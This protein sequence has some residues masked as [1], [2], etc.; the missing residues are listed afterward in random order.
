MTTTKRASVA[1]AQPR[2]GLPSFSDNQYSVARVFPSGHRIWPGP[3]CIDTDGTRRKAKWCAL[4]IAG[5][6]MDDALDRVRREDAERREREATRTR[7]IAL[8][9][10]R[11]RARLARFRAWLVELRGYT[12]AAWRAGGF[13]SP[14]AFVIHEADRGH[15]WPFH[16]MRGHWA[17]RWSR[18]FMHDTHGDLGRELVDSPEWASL[19]W[20]REPAEV[21]QVERFRRRLRDVE[22]LEVSRA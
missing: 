15:S 4:V 10:E 19:P 3:E 16:I 2:R 18:A 14:E 22:A 13:I 20:Q 12:V 6:D 17:L 11:A 7:G 21:I 9:H 1:Q 8:A 5:A